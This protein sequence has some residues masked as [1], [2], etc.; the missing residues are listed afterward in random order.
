M[1]TEQ[2]TST[3]KSGKRNASSKKYKTEI[4]KVLN[5][6]KRRKILSVSFKSCGI[7]IQNVAFCDS[8]YVKVKYMSDI[9]KS[10]FSYELINEA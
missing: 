8:E 1:N 7:Q 6:D 3:N 4:C 5:F 2:K 9:G 10:D